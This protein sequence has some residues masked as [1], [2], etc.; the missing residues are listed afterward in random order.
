MEATLRQLLRKHGV[1]AHL[2]VAAT[3]DRGELSF[4]IDT[5]PRAEKFIFGRINNAQ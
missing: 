3:F 1:M 4:T 5:D 2:K